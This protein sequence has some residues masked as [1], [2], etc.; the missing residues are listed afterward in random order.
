MNKSEIVGK[1]IPSFQFIDC[2]NLYGHTDKIRII[3]ATE[4]VMSQKIHIKIINALMS[5]KK[6]YRL[7]NILIR[8]LICHS[9]VV[10]LL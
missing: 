4:N 9:I 6:E 5:N 8:Y 10:M 1:Y 7:K 2:I 3:I